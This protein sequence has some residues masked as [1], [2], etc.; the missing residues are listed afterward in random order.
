MAQQFDVAVL[1]AGPGGYTAAIR[2]AQLGFKT[3]CIDDWKNN[4]GKPSLGGTCLNVGCIPSKALLESSENYERVVHKFAEHGIKAAGVQVDMATMLA[5]KDKIVD[6][7]TGGIALLFKKNKVASL[8]GKGS[9]VAGGDVYSIEIRDGDR[10]DTIEA[11]HVIIATGSLPRPLAE[12]PV[13]HDRILDNA[14]ALALGEIPKRLGVI[15]AG[16]IGLEM[17]S[18]WRR[19]GSD[20]T[21]LEALPAF[22]PAVDEQVAK[23]AF[24]V[25]NGPLDLKIFTGVKLTSVKP[26]KKAVAVTYVNRDGNTQMADFDRLIVAIGRVPNTSG[27]G[28]EKVGLKLDARGYV[29]VDESNRTNLPNVFAI[30]DAVRGPMLAHKSSE[31]GVAAAETIAGQVSHV[32][33]DTIPW[34]IYTSP[35][36]AWVGKTEQQLKA[37]GLP[38]RVGQFPFIASGRARALGE[39]AGF[40]KML[41][42]SETDRILGVHIIGPYASELIAEAVVAMEFG[43]SAEDIARIVHAH[44]TLSEAMHEA[45][46]GVHKRTLNI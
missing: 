29:E 7:F 43:A 35:E 24:R 21:I 27:I 34:V 36:I 33:L 4:Q 26:G 18:V 44:P 32:N 46:L 40:M 6:T 39:T 10:T 2:A 15:G 41:A 3:V 22:L 28:A 37:E 19:L 20:V 5:R 17:G 13:D 30:G 12:A 11:K 14:S 1:G 25:F 9:F 16:V 38:Y 45:A 42:H 31:E 8:H 23:E